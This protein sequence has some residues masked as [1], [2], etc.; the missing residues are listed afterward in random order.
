MGLEM[1]FEKTG[2]QQESRGMVNGDL[3]HQIANHADGNQVDNTDSS[4]MNATT[5]NSD[6]SETTAD[7]VIP[8]TPPSKEHQLNILKTSILARL[9]LSSTV[10]LFP[11]KWYD[12]FSSWARGT[13]GNEPGRVDPAGTLLDLDGV[14]KEDAIEHRDWLVTNEQGW[15][16]IKRW[17]D[18]LSLSLP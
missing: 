10:Y 11:T 4:S 2:Q 7:I 12:A 15:S 9:D 18:T 13:S 8:S 3:S 5:S 16:L 1:D 17:Y 6:S 14:L